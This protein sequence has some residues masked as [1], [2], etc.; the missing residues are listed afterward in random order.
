MAFEE[1]YQISKNQ[2]VKNFSK[3][4]KKHN[5][6]EIEF[7]FIKDESQ[8]LQIIKSWDRVVKA[9]FSLSPT[10]P[11]SKE[12]FKKLDEFIRKSRAKKAK[13]EFRNDEQ[14]LSF[15]KES[16]AAEG[17]AM[18]SAGYGDYSI[19]GT[20][21]NIGQAI[22]SN[23]LLIRKNL[24]LIDSLEPLSVEVLKEIRQIVESMNE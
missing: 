3:F 14:G 5:E 22:K 13:L 11:D 19:L 4:W 17:L 12:D 8:A 24:V 23:S 18:A 7:E 21:N 10:N 6:S 16:P 20:K 15:D 2:F 9:K 1:K